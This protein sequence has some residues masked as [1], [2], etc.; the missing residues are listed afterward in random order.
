MNKI[1]LVLEGGG[2]RG[3]FTGGVID[4]FLDNNIEFDY[5][6]GVSAGACNSLS[7]IAKARGF[8]K[9]CMMQDDKKNA[10][11]A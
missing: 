3:I 4:C 9:Q 10:L 1:A 5:V 8:T 6:C 11:V 2:L 7:Y